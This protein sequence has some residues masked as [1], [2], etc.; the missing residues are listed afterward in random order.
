MTKLPLLDAERANL[1]LQQIMVLCG[2]CDS[3]VCHTR[4]ELQRWQAT[5]GGGN[6]SHA[7]DV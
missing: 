3:V 5:L 2:K 1:L 7:A 4:K 6:E